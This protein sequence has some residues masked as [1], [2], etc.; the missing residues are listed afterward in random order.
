[1]DITNY[2][3][4]ENYIN[5]LDKKI[6]CII[7]LAALNL[8]KS[9]EN[10]INA[11]EININGTTNMLKIA[12]KKNIPFIILSTGAVFSSQ[13]CNYIFNENHFANPNCM[14]GITKLASEKIALNY[15]KTILIRTGWLFGGNKKD[16]YK[17]VENV[18]NNLIN[19]NEVNASNDFY[20]SPTYVID[21]I[22]KMKYLILNKKYGTHN[23]VNDGKACGYDIANEIALLLNKNK[24]LIISLN[25]ENIPNGGPIR[26]NSEILESVYNFNKMRSWKEALKEY[27]NI[28]IK[29]DLKIIKNNIWN[30]RYKCRLCDSQNLFIFFKLE[31]TPQANHFVK[32]PINQELIPLDI[33]I[34]KDC[35]HIQLIQILNPSYQYSNYFYVSNT[36]STMKIHLKNS[37]N[38]FI[39]KNKIKKND[40]ILEIGANDGT[41]IDYLLENGFTN[42]LG[43][44]PAINIHKTHKLP[45]ICDFFSSK[46]LDQLK[47][48]YNS[49]KLIYAFHC[50]A[51][52]ENIQDI[53]KTIY[54]LLDNDGVFIMEVGYF[55]EVFKNKLFDTIYHEHIDYHTCTVLDS[56]SKKNLLLLYDVYVNNIQGGSIQFF[57][58]KNM[59][60]VV[61]DNVKNIIKKENE[62]DIFNIKNLINWQ[63]KIIL[64]SK[65][66]FFILNSFKFFGKKIAGYGASAKSTT[67]LYNCRLNKN[68]I[69]FIIDDSKYKKEHYTPGLHIPIK[70]LD[71]LDTIQ[72]DYIIILSWNFTSDIIKNLEKYR[73]NGL[74]IIVPFP[75]INIL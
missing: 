57:F 54:E 25:K 4:I 42:I 33:S 40:N 18:I 27:V 48:K 32:E 50:C 43:I 26:S 39:I 46:L 41:C 67:F 15:N 69:D 45:I 74:R 71:I 53:F 37:I 55:Y 73:I 70:P 3:S 5:N 24:N 63:K 22:N 23:I 8:R 1:M 52:I 38:N 20:G 29:K 28:F 68:L 47:N 44:D 75:E 64:Q 17:F 9:E 59:S 14:Y 13:N 60:R 34:C 58:S 31:K 65:D 2:I 35:K 21:L 72:I 7:H 61:N 49:F 6:S 36:S 19:D 66:I 10:H 16:D 51:H 12:Q 56:F 11:I 62:L 30:N